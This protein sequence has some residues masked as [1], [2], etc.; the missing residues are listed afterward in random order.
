MRFALLKFNEKKIIIVTLWID[1]YASNMAKEKVAF[2]T[3]CNCHCVCW[4]FDNF[5]VSSLLG[6]IQRKLI[7]FSYTMNW[8]KKRRT[9]FIL[10]NARNVKSYVCNQ[11]HVGWPLWKACIMLAFPAL[12]I[13][14]QKFEFNCRLNLMDFF[15]NFLIKFLEINFCS[16][17]LRFFYEFKVRWHISW[18]EF[19]DFTY[20]MQSAAIVIDETIKKTSDRKNA[21]ILQQEWIKWQNEWRSTFLPSIISKYWIF[22]FHWNP[23]Y[24]I[25][26]LILRL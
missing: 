8:H 21:V 17:I 22:I 7:S 20:Q 4:A 6:H 9:T 11:L 24:E 19:L 14:L 26:L 25:L 23:V 10:S 3:H 16:G 5:N 2:F 12:R 18:S 1:R 13:L 15:W